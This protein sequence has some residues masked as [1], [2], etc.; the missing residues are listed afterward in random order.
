MPHFKN[1]IVMF[2]GPT[3]GLGKSFVSAN[4][5]AVMAASGKRVLLIDADLRNGHL[6]RYFGVSREQG[7]SRG[8]HA[9]AMPRRRR[10]SI[11]A[12]WKTST[13][14]RP[15]RCRRTVPNSCCT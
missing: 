6:H 2:A 14:S 5:A 4:F 11:T 7:L 1:N 10:R 3:R 13:S 8:D 9:A 15:A 12:C